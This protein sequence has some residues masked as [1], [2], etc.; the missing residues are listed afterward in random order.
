MAKRRSRT[1]KRKVRRSKT[2]NYHKRKSHKKT[3][4]RKTLEKRR[5]RKTLA[6]KRR[7]SKKKRT[8]RRKRRMRG[9]AESKDGPAAYKIIVINDAGEEIDDETAIHFLHNKYLYHSDVSVDY[10]CVDGSM[11]GYKRV[12]RLKRLIPTLRKNV[13]SLSNYKP[14]HGTTQTIILQIGPIEPTQSESVNNL[15]KYMK[16]NGGYKYV[17]LGNLGTT[18]NSQDDRIHMARH[19]HDNA[20]EK[21]VVDQPYEKYTPLTIGNYTTGI[22]NEIYIVAFRNTLGRAPAL[23]YTAHLVGPKGAN[24][25]TAKSIYNGI[26]GGN[27]FESLE[28]DHECI[29]QAKQYFDTR[30][31]D[32]E[33]NIFGTLRYHAV[34]A[35]HPPALAHACNFYKSRQVQLSQTLQSQEEGLARMLQAF[36]NLFKTERIYYSSEECLK[37]DVIESQGSKLGDI[38]TTFK[39][40]LQGKN[41]ELTPAY[42]L[43]AA[44]K[45][46]KLLEGD[47]EGDRISRLSPPPT[48]MELRQMDNPKLKHK[49]GADERRRTDNI[50]LRRS[51]RLA[52]V[53]KAR[54]RK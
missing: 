53:H 54:N 34:N 18:F 29:Q 50:K 43:K 22:Q 14:S 15:V 27:G 31:R 5:K 10:V 36:K 21:Y 3:R 32:N 6:K 44:K 37:T 52:A 47:L 30:Q 38:F 48:K 26:T 17:L 13:Y 45:V 42:D 16:S 24:Y 49:R 20:D 2:R 51:K 39:T 12:Q 46:V 33:G 8:S 28:I 40:Q 11:E 23:L 9:G 19:I 25:E 4:K 41:I 7:R 35:D 1:L